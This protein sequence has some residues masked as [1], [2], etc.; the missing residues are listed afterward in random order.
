MIRPV[1]RRLAPL[2][3][4]LLALALTG[5]APSPERV[6]KRMID[7]QGGFFQNEQERKDGLRYCVELKSQQK[8]ENP[9]KYECEADCV[10]SEHDLVA[11][12][13]C[14]AKCK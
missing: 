9:K 3:S 14:N 13:E 8:R 6:C 4:I 11:A 7:L 10:L 12:S 2:S 5:C 1:M